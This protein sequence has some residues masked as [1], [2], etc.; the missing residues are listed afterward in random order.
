LTYLA[1][2]YKTAPLKNGF[3][4]HTQSVQSSFS[5][6]VSDALATSTPHPEVFEGAFAANFRRL[7]PACQCKFPKTVKASTKGTRKDKP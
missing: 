2:A 5:L 3:S 7:F 1:F 6:G 4:L